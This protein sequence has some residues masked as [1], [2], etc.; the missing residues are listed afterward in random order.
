MQHRFF[1]QEETLAVTRSDREKSESRKR[2]SS[3]RK[4]QGA[5]IFLCW[6]GK[7]VVIVLS[8]SLAKGE[9]WKYATEGIFFSFFLPSKKKKLLSSSNHERKAQDKM[10]LMFAGQELLWRGRERVNK[11]TCINNYSTIFVA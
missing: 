9:L 3:Q 5:H 8:V 4:I 11:R 1:R 6:A 2:K 7:L 10:F